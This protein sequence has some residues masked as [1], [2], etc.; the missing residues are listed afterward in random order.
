[1]CTFWI[2]VPFKIVDNLS[3]FNEN[4]TQTNLMTYFRYK[5]TIKEKIQDIKI[6]AFENILN[7]GYEKIFVFI[8][9]H[10]FVIAWKKWFYP[11][12]PSKSWGTT[13]PLAP[14]P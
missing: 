4:Q 11:Y 2:V 9:K 3:I 13:T 12:F 1:M 8:Y 7:L 14:L 6:G 10:F 5:K